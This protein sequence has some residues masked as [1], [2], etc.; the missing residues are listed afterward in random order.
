MNKSSLQ[1]ITGYLLILGAGLLIMSQVVPWGILGPNISSG[2]EWY[3]WGV[4]GYLGGGKK[5]WI[6]FFTQKHEMVFPKGANMA[7]LIRFAFPMNII[8][9]LV[10]AI[11]IYRREKYSI[12]G[13]HMECLSAGIILLASIIFYVVAINDITTSTGVFGLYH[14]YIGFFLSIS[15]IA[16]FFISTG[17]ILYSKKR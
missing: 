7:G 15:A 12:K 13:G 5:E 4:H 11:A 9:I 2:I 1:T 3:S 8:S 17:I 10:A 6:N 14:W 16:I